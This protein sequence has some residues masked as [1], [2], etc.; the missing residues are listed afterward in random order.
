MIKVTVQAEGKAP[1]TREF[2]NQNDAT[3]HTQGLLRTARIHNVT[4]VSLVNN[5]WKVI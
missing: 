3:K 1:V 4:I 2:A 5:G